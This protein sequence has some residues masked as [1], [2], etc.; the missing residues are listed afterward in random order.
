MRTTR[1]DIDVMFGRV[2]A[3]GRALGFNNV[4]GWHIYSAYGNKYW[5]YETVGTSGSSGLFMPD[6]FLGVGTAAAQAS[7]FAIARTLEEILYRID[8]NTRPERRLA[9]VVAYEGP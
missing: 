8:T 9:K 4:D 3:A 5:L 6:G 2:V 1:K 7:L